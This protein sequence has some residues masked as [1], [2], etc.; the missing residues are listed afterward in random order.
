MK[1]AMNEEG[2]VERISGLEEVQRTA[3]AIADGGVDWDD[4]EEAV[5]EGEGELV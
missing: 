4:D 2:Y 1:K 3:A 5:E